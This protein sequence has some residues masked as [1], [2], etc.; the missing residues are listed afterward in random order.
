MEVAAALS[1]E[2]CIRAIRAAHSP[3]PKVNFYYNAMGLDLVHAHL[4]VPGC[5]GRGFGSGTSAHEALIWLLGLW[6]CTGST[7][8]KMRLASPTCFF[9]GRSFRFLSAWSMPFVLR[10]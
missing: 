2:D 1:L 4:E 3:S 7:C 10:V 9:A 8:I 6:V 5:V